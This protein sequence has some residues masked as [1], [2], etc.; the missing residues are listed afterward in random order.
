MHVA[1]LHNFSIHYIDMTIARVNSYYGK[2]NKTV[3]LSGVQCNGEETTISECVYTRFSLEDGRTIP[4]AVA[5]VRCAVSPSTASSTGQAAISGALGGVIVVL[6][7]I[8]IAIVVAV[9]IL[10]R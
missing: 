4:D 6:L 5:G 7:L 3:H 2:P 1:L 8:I 10:Y 9:L